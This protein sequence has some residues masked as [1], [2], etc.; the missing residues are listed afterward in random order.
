ME[1]MSHTRSFYSTNYVAL[2]SW[3]I[4]RNSQGIK[5]KRLLHV[6]PRN[7]CH[8]PDLSIQ[9]IMFLQFFGN[10]KEFLRNQRNKVIPRNLC[11]IPDLVIQQI[12]FL[13]FLGT[14]FSIEPC[15]ANF[16][17]KA[18]QILAKQRN[19]VLTLTSILLFPRTPKVFH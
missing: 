18:I 13:Q 10:S 8:I 4:P 7:P 17:G 11:H 3:I 5:Q 1:P 6:I 16:L 9:R 2:I 14:R 15:F 19:K 12:M